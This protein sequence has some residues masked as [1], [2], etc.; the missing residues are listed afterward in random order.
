MKTEYTKINSNWITVITEQEARTNTTD[1]IYYLEWISE[2]TDY[3]DWKRAKDSDIEKKSMFVLD[4][5]IRN[6]FKKIYSEDISN[7][8]IKKEGSLLS[9]NLIIEDEFFWEWNKI[10]FTWNWLHIYYKWDPTS[11]TKEQYSMWVNRIYKQWDKIMWWYLKV[12]FA[13]KNIA[14]ILRL[15]WTIN[16]KN[17]AKVEILAEQ[18]INS[19][20]F[21]FIKTFAN[22]E[23]E[24]IIKEQQKRK[25]EIEEKMKDYWKDWNKFYEE[26]NSIPAYQIAELLIP[27]KYDW[28]KNFKNWKKWF[29]RYFFNSDTNTICNGWSRHFNFWWSES[30]FNNFS[31]VKHFNNWEDKYVFK[32]FKN[33]IK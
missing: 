30:C 16:Q 21:W 22:S 4:L 17:W 2:N 31:L 33:L 14:R 8:D 19:R 5:D 9:E 20:L 27:F 24:E 29:C 3:S 11:F 12:D 1:N 28:K 15:P 25:K 13:C 23:Q 6:E 18:D 26:I 32:Y 7:E 10:V